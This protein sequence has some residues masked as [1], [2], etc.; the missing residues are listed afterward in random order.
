MR[1][2]ILPK[3]T[4]AEATIKSTNHTSFI[5]ITPDARPNQRLN[6]VSFFVEK[7]NELDV[8][9]QWKN[10][11]SL[12]YHPKGTPRKLIFVCSVEWA[13]S[14]MNNKIANNN[15]N[16]KPWGKSL[17]DNRLSDHDVAW[18]WW[19][20]F[21]AYSSKTKADQKT[22]EAKILVSSW[23]D[24]VEQEYIDHYHLINN[25]SCLDVEDVQAIAREVWG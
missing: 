4:K 3:S 11:I 22:I 1:L 6:E 12:K 18:S 10:S 21:S 2:G 7:A 19:G 13:W 17:W 20:D 24:E 5:Q 14:T 25:T 15:I 8:F 23:K 16:L 9:I